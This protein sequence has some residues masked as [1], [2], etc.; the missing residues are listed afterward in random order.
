MYANASYY[1][2]DS[3]AL[4]NTY[5]AYAAIYRTQLWV[6]TVVRKLAMA[7][8]R[9]PFE[10]KGRINETDSINENGPLTELLARPNVNMSGFKLW[11]WT[12]STRDVYG[13][14]FWLKLRDRNGRVRELHPMHPTN[15]IVRRLDDGGIGYVYSNGTANTSTC[16]SSRRRTSSR[17]RRTT[18]RTSSVASRRSRASG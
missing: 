14:A 10:I 15:V 3:L 2:T 18:R 7:T 1:S 8:A 13:E 12:S 4:L 11:E 17:S 5:A 16:R 9:M 6:G